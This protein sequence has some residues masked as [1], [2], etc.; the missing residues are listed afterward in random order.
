MSSS[1]EASLPIIR[2]QVVEDIKSSADKLKRK[3][4]AVLLDDSSDDSSCPSWLK[5]D[6]AQD[7][8]ASKE[9]PKTDG[10]TQN[11]DGQA[12][13]TDIKSKS[14][15][16]KSKA[17][18][19]IYLLSSSSDSEDDVPLAARKADIE[20]ED[21]PPTQP[22]QPT[23]L[24]QTTHITEMTQLS[25]PDETPT[26][27]ETATKSPK[28]STKKSS[29]KKQKMDNATT[30][31]STAKKSSPGI[32]AGKGDRKSV[33]V[34]VPDKLPGSKLV[35]ELE[36]SKEIIAGAT[37]LSGDTG[38]IGRI[39]QRII[40]AAGGSTVECHELDL[41]G[42]MYNV[43]PAV[44]PGTIMVLNF[45]GEDAKIEMMTDSFVQLRED[46]RFRSDENEKAMQAWLEEDDDN[47]VQLRTQGSGGVV[48][49]AKGAK[50]G[51]KAK[52]AAKKPSA[53]KPPAKKPSAKKPSAKK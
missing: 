45:Q 49:G 40:P 2:R 22:T 23:Q 30:M 1:S 26:Q 39:L 42:R 31:K 15:S 53:K 25:Q 21:L 14:K 8:A 33:N 17:T 46:M 6:K 34:I 27:P 3:R 7:D 11:K 29:A 12:A 20:L 24:T 5:N 16:E 44:F 32:L 36:S 41:K 50:K 48:K 43:T 4:A 38:A 51:G 28:E 19:M 52:A 10:D 37:D 18:Q 9:T 47:D 35:L 13:F